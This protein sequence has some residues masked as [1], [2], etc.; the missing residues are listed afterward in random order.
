MNALPILKTPQK[1]IQFCS[2]TVLTIVFYFII[3]AN[4]Y[5][6]KLMIKIKNILEFIS[7]NFLIIKK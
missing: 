4:K 7:F 6:S 2:V 1:Q 3:F 5:N